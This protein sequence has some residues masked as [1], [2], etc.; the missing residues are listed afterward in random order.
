MTHHRH[1][2]EGDHTICIN[3]PFEARENAGTSG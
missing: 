2:G 3:Q 1:P